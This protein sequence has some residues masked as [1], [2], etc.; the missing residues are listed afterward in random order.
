MFFLSALPIGLAMIIFEATLS[1]R[2]FGLAPETHLLEKLAR[3]IPA[4]LGVYAAVKL[5]QLAAEGKLALLFSSGINSLLFWAE[6]ILGVVI[7]AALFSMKSIRASA[8][9]LF[10]SA[11]L[12]LLGMIL[13][14]FNV[15][16]LAVK[17]LGDVTYIPSVPEVSISVAILAA[18]ILAFGLAGKLLPLFQHQEHEHSAVPAPVA[19]D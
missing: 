13:N 15:S 6:I 9:G 18:G 14:R 10:N 12:L 7:P 16:W 17:H 4:T 11:I 3:Y 1:G 2:A 5:L 19:G 8:Q